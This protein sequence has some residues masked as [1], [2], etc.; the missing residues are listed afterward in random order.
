MS[1]KLENII[2]SGFGI[3]CVVFISSSLMFISYVSNTETYHDEML[4][5]QKQQL[6][7]METQIGEKNAK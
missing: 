6:V 2:C 5:L 1:N 7:F 3:I 4:K